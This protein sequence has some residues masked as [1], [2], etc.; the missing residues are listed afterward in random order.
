MK[1]QLVFYSLI[2]SVSFFQSCD[3]TG[4]GEIIIN[5]EPI[6][7]QSDWFDI[8]VIDNKT[9]IFHEPNS[10]EGNTSYLLIGSNRN[11]MFDTGTGENSTVNGS[12]IKHLIQQ[13]SDLPVGLLLSHLHYD[14]VQNIGEF[15][16]IIFPDLSE[17]RNR[18]TANNVFTFTNQDLIVGNTPSE[19]TVD[20]WFPMNTD[21]DLGDRTIEL[22]HVPGHSK[23]SVVMIDKTNKMVFLGDFLYNGEVFL[24]DNNDVSAY[25]ASATFLLNQIDA[26]YKLYGAHGTPEVA[27]SKLTL[28]KDFLECIESQNCTAVSSTLFGDP[29]LIYTYQGMEIVI[30]Q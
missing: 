8:E 13:A 23:E 11:I 6:N 27:F 15:D 1:N 30:F 7:L 24:F 21:I 20:E 29:V 19:I 17:L 22:V 10:I 5:G 14:H 16:H 3:S 9:V 2:I 18:V 26:T 28:L 12:K 25:A 4:G